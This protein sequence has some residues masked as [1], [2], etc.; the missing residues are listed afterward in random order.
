VF[1]KSHRAL[2][3]RQIIPVNRDYEISAVRLFAFL[4]LF[5]AL[6]VNQ[7][8][9]AFSLTAPV[10]QAAVGAVDGSLYIDL[11]QDEVSVSKANFNHRRSSSFTTA[12]AGV[13]ENI[14]SDEILARARLNGAVRVIVQLRIP[15]GPDE[16]RDQRI[17][18]ARQGLLRELVPVAYRVVRSYTA[19][20]ALA[21]E[22]SHAALQVLNPSFH[23]LRAD[24]DELAAPFIKPGPL[25]PSVNGVRDRERE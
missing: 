10:T 1:W 15:A 9:L 24:E 12:A 13:Q 8:A 11:A 16:T 19:I 20:S 6:C 18:A 14:V 7:A 5:C 17:D 4:S 3:S 2:A 25:A 23:V 22:S 21:L